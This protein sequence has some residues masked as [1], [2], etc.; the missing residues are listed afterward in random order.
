MEVLYWA[1]IY[2]VRFMP[3]YLRHPYSHW[4]LAGSSPGIPPSH[5][6]PCVPLPPMLTSVQVYQFARSR[7]DIWRTRHTVDVS[8]HHALQVV[9]LEE[10]LHLSWE[11][12][13]Q[14]FF[15]Q[16]RT[17][18][19]WINRIYS[20]VHLPATVSFLVGL[21]WYCVTRTRSRTM[22][23]SWQNVTA[24]PEIN[25]R[26]YEAQR[27]ALAVS[28]L[29]AFVV[30]STWPCMPPRLLDDKD[31]GAANGGLQAKFGFVDT[32]HARNGAVSIWYVP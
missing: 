5:F 8:R 19:W 7:L 24:S 28:N 13:I 22:S 16:S 32:V 21:Y 1:L 18:M 2:S 29:L 9:W 12:A 4:L 17:T 31:G 14:R 15:L 6:L 10:Y 26:I 20:Y 23:V 25:S 11:P 27:R 3:Q 30:F